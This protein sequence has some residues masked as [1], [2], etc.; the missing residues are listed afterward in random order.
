MADPIVVLADRCHSSC[1]R[2][3]V[4]HNPCGPDAHDERPVGRSSLSHPT[5]QKG[6]QGPL[7]STTTVVPIFR[8]RSGIDRLSRADLLADLGH[9]PIVLCLNRP[10]TLCMPRFQLAIGLHPQ[11]RRPLIMFPHACAWCIRLFAPGD[12]CQPCFDRLLCPCR[13]AWSR[14]A[15]G[16]RPGAVVP[17]PLSPS[18]TDEPRVPLT[19]AR[20][21]TPVGHDGQARGRHPHVAGG[22]AGLS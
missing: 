20:P 22:H 8:Q 21:S 1:V 15:H 16:R 11:T 17:D 12:L 13:R 5:T 18:L 14:T 9:L 10:T 19:A 4:H 2:G 7:Y 6:P 3:L